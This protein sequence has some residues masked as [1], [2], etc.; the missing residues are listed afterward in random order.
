[1]GLFDRKFCDICG[2]KIGLLGNHACADGNLCSGCVGKLSPFFT[3]RKTST[4]DQLREQLTYREENRE[5]LA[6]FH[7]TRSYGSGSTK[8][9]AD[10]EQGCFVLSR[11]GDL[12]QQNPDL[13][14]FNDVTGARLDIPE[15]KREIYGRAPDGSRVSYNP[16]RY[17]YSYNFVLYI[18]VNNPYFSELRVQLNGAALDGHD[19]MGCQRMKEEGD[20]LVKLLQLRR[21]QQQQKEAARGPR[22]CPFCGAVTK[23]DKN[24]CCEYCG[25]KIL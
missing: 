13:I 7:P 11:G 20:G 10:E 14:S 19:R 21:M 12:R 18:T 23:P 1:M 6:D 16:R 15:T 25:S 2:E 9:L 4:L 8:L 5:K 17:E 24:G 22:S 3:A